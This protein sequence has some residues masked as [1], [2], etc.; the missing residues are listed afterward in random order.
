MSPP[1]TLLTDSS[2]TLIPPLIEKQQ[3]TQTLLNQLK[4]R[5]YQNMQIIKKYLRKINKKQ[6]QTIQ[7]LPNRQSIQSE[8]KVIEPIQ[9][10]EMQEVIE[11]C[12]KSEMDESENE[13]KT[14]QTL[15]DSSLFTTID[16]NNQ[17]PT[18]TILAQINTT[19]LLI[20][21]NA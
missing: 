20:Q 18:H 8:V 19:K 13:P 11:T 3:T 2:P 10:N 12:V 6:M 21:K 1:E 16:S 5:N 4:A 9:S 17:Q 15:K 7:P 14:D